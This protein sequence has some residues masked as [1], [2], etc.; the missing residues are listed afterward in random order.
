M[1][2]WDKRL[3]EL[4]GG[5]VTS[6]IIEGE[7]ELSCDIYYGL[8]ILLPTGESKD[9]IF[10]MDEEDNGAGRFDIYDSEI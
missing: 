2:Y 9:I 4:I 3:S 1:G 7:G 10:L 6:V 8:R 5:T